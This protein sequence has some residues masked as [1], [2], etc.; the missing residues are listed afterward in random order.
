MKTLGLALSFRNCW[1]PAFAGM[2]RCAAAQQFLVILNSRVRGDDEACPGVV[3][4]ELLDSRLPGN[5][6]MGCCV[7]ISG[8]PVFPS[9]WT[10]RCAADFSVSGLRDFPLCQ[11]DVN[12]VE[13]FFEKPV[14]WPGG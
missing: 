3:L 11:N 14:R 7:I 2:T 9:S 13:G 8:T 5:D 10:R 12:G 4:Q 6:E 1:I